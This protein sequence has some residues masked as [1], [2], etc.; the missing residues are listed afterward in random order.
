MVEC[1]CHFSPRTTPPDLRP[2][3]RRVEVTKS[4]LYIYNVIGSWD[5]FVGV[6]G[7]S[8]VLIVVRVL[9]PKAV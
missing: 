5:K 6:G 9:R 7:V 4:R 3:F 2:V 8:G 1:T